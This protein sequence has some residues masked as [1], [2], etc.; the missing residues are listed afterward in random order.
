MVVLVLVEALVN[1]FVLVLVLAMSA[2]L[3]FSLLWQRHKQRSNVHGEH[4]ETRTKP[5]WDERLPNDHRPPSQRNYIGIIATWLDLAALRATL[6][7]SAKK[8]G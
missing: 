5:N 2:F 7:R 8:H 3:Y 4:S 1:V 6:A